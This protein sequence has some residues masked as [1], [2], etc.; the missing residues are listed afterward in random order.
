MGGEGSGRRKREGV[1]RYASGIIRPPSERVEPLGPIHRIK[2]VSKSGK[3]NY[4]L[5]TAKEAGIPRQNSNARNAEEAE[6]YEAKTE[7]L[8]LLRGV[9]GDYGLIHWLS[10][11]EH[12]RQE[13]SDLYNV[14]S[15]KEIME[16][17]KEK[18]NE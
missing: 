7:H 13:L 14:P 10:L 15:I 8:T 6:F 17:R 11:D 9:I 18:E 4:R 12:D 16:A 2:I 1:E 5:P 3:V